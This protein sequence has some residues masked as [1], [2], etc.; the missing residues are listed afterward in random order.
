MRIFQIWRRSVWP[1]SVIAITSAKEAMFHR[2]SVC[3][4]V[5]NLCKN[6]WSDLYKKFI[7]DAHLDKKVLFKFWKPRAAGIFLQDFFNILELEAFLPHGSYCWKNCLGFSW[8]FHQRCILRQQNTH[9]ILAF[10]ISGFFNRI[11][12]GGGLILLLLITP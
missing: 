8:K 3:L 7:K 1:V 2:A 10:I 4:S 12:L 11:C 5:S 9:E 6:Y